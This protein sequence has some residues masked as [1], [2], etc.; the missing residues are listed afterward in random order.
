MLQDWTIQA[1]SGRCDVTGEPFADREPFYT[2]LYRDRHDALSRRD[3]SEAGWRQLRADPRAARP[4]SFWRSKFT[5]PAPAAPDAL[6]RADA[7]T[8]LRRFLADHRPEHGRAVYILALMLERKRLLRQ[9]DAQTDPATDQR[10]LF[11]EH[12]KTGESFA[13]LDPGLKLD[14]LDAVQREVSDLLRPA[15]AADAGG[16]G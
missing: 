6:P 3:V 5:P 7:E 9:T 1:R 10:I 12:V 4:F 14:Q 15:Q 13:V 8:L 2:L 16:P 11:Y